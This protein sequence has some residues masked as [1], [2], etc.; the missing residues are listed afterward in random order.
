MPLGLEWR[1]QGG[2]GWGGEVGLVGT[3]Q[4]ST[5]TPCLEQALADYWYYADVL[6]SDSESLFWKEFFYL[7]SFLDF[8]IRL[9]EMKKNLKIVIWT[10]SHSLILM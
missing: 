8:N 2:W 5:M 7:E 1:K 6:P 4:S 3:G 10:V 9:F